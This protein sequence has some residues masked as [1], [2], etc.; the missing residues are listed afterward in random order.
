[1]PCNSDYMIPTVKE[2]KLQETAQLLEYVLHKLGRIVP[3]WVSRAGGEVYCAE[4]RTVPIL[5]LI[6]DQLTVEQAALFAD[7]S[8]RP[9]RK[10]ADWCE[11]HQRADEARKAREAKEAGKEALRRTALAKLTKEERDALNL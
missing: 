4:T 2:E 3:A 1:M 9:N 5:C 8:Q 6:M 10:L 7:I 11:E